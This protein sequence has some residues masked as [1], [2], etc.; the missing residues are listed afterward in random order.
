[1]SPAQ[2]VGG[3][4]SSHARSRSHPQG[5]DSQGKAKE[6]EK[7]EVRGNHDGGRAL[8]FLLPAPG[9]ANFRRGAGQGSMRENF[10]LESLGSTV[11]GLGAGQG[12]SAEVGAGVASLVLWVEGRVADPEVAQVPS[13]L[14]RLDLP[15]PQRLRG[16]R[17]RGVSERHFVSRRTGRASS[18]AVVVGAESHTRRQLRAVAGK[19]GLPTRD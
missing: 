15:T 14:V 16:V 10:S 4:S 6:G 9:R 11:N 12:G 7:G 5:L 3:G 13:I 8:F 18:L 19:A 17:D 2:S 1:M